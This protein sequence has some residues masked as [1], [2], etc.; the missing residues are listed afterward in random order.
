MKKNEEIVVNL[1]TEEEH[2]SV[3]NLSDADKKN[4]DRIKEKLRAEL[5][6]EILKEME[7]Q[8]QLEKAKEQQSQQASQPAQH[9]QSPSLCD[10]RTLPPE[11][12]GRGNTDCGICRLGLAPVL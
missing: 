2:E 9:Q 8:E 4:V 11:V 6:I 5:G 1:K 3:R 7:R 10:S 12:G